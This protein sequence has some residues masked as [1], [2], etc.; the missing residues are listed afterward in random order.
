MSKFHA[1]GF[2]TFVRS[3]STAKEEEEGAQ[4]DLFDFEH[5]LGGVDSV[6]YAPPA[7]ESDSDDIEAV[8]SYS[9]DEI[10]DTHELDEVLFNRPSR[11]RRRGSWE[12][13]KQRRIRNERHVEEEEESPLSFSEESKMSL[14]PLRVSTTRTK[15]KGKGGGVSSKYSSERLVQ[16]ALLSHQTLISKQE[17]VLLDMEAAVHRLTDVGETIGIELEEHNEY[18]LLF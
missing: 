16:E 17:E 13:E 2:E 1:G 14:P 3:S 7:V 10:E 15:N 6:L 12:R 11:H 8:C 4:D 18:V 5:E 9:E